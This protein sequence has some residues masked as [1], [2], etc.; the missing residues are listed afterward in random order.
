MIFIINP[1]LN[2]ILVYLDNINSSLGNLA[3]SSYGNSNYISNTS[4][5]EPFNIPTGIDNTLTTLTY[6]STINNIQIIE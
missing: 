1:S 2:E 6:N 5:T 3:I 4:A